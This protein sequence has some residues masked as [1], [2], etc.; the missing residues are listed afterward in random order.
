[1]RY[2]VTHETRYHY[3]APVSLCY[4]LAHLTPATLPGQTC[5]GSRIDIQPL[6]AARHERVDFFGN[7][8]VYFLTRQLHQELSVRAV[9]EVDVSGSMPPPPEVSAPWESVRKA[10]TE[11]AGAELGEVRQFLLESPLVRA[12]VELNGY[13]TAAFTP[14]RPILEAVAELMGS[15]HRDFAYDPHFTTVSTPLSAVM[16]HRR[17]VC[18]DFAHLAIA[19]LRAQGLPARYVSGYLETEPPPGGPRLVGADASHAWFSVYVP[20]LDWVDFDPTNDQVPS[21]R[22]ITTAHGRD[23]S[24]VPPLKGVLYGGGQH[25]LEVAVDVMRLPN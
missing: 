15:I 25:T 8:T 4:S 20:G 22:Y 1:M 19:C 6:P 3:S 18:Q 10:V 7:R 14:G 2:R 17:G 11:G 24:D 23:Y 21:D 16:E 12:D 13:A 9:S 5:L